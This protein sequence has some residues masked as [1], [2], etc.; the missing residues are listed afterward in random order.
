MIQP[1]L[2]KH[3]VCY[4]FTDEGMELPVIDITH[5]AFRVHISKEQLVH[6]EHEFEA[7]Q[8]KQAKIPRFISKI[9]HKIF[10][11]K[12]M[13]GKALMG[14]QDSYLGGLHTYIMKLGED[15]VQGVLVNK[16]D[17]ELLKSLPAL[18]L[19]LRLQDM[20]RMLVDTAVPML[21]EYPSLPLYMINIA[22]G[23]ASDS[24]NTLILLKKE[25]PGLIEGREII[26]KVLDV[27]QK[28]PDF[29]A[30]S[31]EALKAKGAPLEGIHAS[32]YYEPYDWSKPEKLFDK[33]KLPE[34]VLVLLSSE[35]GF[36]EYC[37]DSTIIN[38]LV[39]LRSLVPQNTA[40]IGTVTRDEGPIIALKLTSTLPTICRSQEAFVKLVEQ[41][42]WQVTDTRMQVFSRVVTLKK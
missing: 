30:H 17:F 6:A 28:G 35:G 15:N 40:F 20:A 8:K 18:A 7:Y 34:N 23:A 33:I 14:A 42:G 3:G 16:I 22:G 5:P 24:L 25:H 41:A 9:L 10:L 12:S 39:A 1:Q 32:L 31:L 37:D 36:F 26:I 13:L 38:N 11:R 21:K 4:A 27:Q 2:K 19:R 29:G